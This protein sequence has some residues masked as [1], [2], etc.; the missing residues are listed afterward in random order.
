[1]RVGIRGSGLIGN[2]LGT[3]F[4]RIG[5]DVVFSYSRDRKKLEQLAKNAGPETRAG[6]P[7]DAVREADAVLLAVHWT[8]V[9]D[10]LAQAGCGA[11][12]YD[13]QVPDPH[14]ALTP[15]SPDL[16]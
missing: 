7:A 4:A 9:D 14:S 6:T 10:E 15:K 8:R 1:M 13:R 11:R 12:I 5:H 3:V 16:T 2:K